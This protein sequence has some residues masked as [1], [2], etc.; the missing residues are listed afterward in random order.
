MTIIKKNRLPSLGWCN[1]LVS[2]LNAQDTRAAMGLETSPEQE[3]GSCRK[4]RR[5]KGRWLYYDAHFGSNLPHPLAVPHELLRILWSHREPWPVFCNSKDRKKIPGTYGIVLHTKE[6]AVLDILWAIKHVKRA[7]A[8][9]PEAANLAILRGGTP[10]WHKRVRE[11]HDKLDLLAKLFP[12]PYLP[13]TVKIRPF[14]QL[15][16]A[17][18]FK[19]FYCDEQGKIKDISRLD[20]N[21]EDEDVAT[22][23]HLLTTVTDQASRVVRDCVNLYAA[24]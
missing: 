14:C 13:T 4:V 16:L 18:T 20:P 15:L 19:V 8:L 6:T 21:A 22:W 7:V 5:S 1:I 24:T 12:P 17:K 10:A 2:R 23:G 11:Y 3:V 9:D